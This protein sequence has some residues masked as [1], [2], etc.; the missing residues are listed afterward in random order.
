MNISPH[1][2]SPVLALASVL[3]L[4]A[5]AWWAYA[6]TRTPIGPGRRRLLLGL[7]LGASLLLSLMIGG[8]SLGLERR[9]ERPPLLRVL[10]DA[11]ASMA[12]PLAEGSSEP[13]RY[14]R[15]LDLLDEMR[16]R[17]GDRLQIEA[18]AFGDG[19]MGPELPYVPTA[20]VTDMGATLAALP[21]AGPGEALLLLSDGVDT[22]GNLWG[23]GLDR[24]RAL[25]ALVLGD[26]VPPPDLRIEDVET[27]SVLRV[28]SRLPMTVRLG[29][30]GDGPRSG[31]IRIL[32]EERL[33]AEQN[34]EIEPDED[35]LRI[36]FSLE[37]EGPGRHG[38]DIEVDGVGPDSS[39]ENNRRRQNLRVVESR[40]R[41]LVLAGRPDWELAALIQGLRGEESLQLEVVTAGPVGGTML[42]RDGAPWTP[43]ESTIHGLLLH[44]WHQTWDP[45]LL[46]DLPLR[47][48]VLFMPGWLERPGRSSL[49]AEWRLNPTPAATLGR[50]LLPTWGEDA[51][52]HAA[53]GGTLIAGIRPGE[54]G[55]LESVLDNPI[56]DGR[57]LMRAEGHPVLTARELGGQRLVACSGRGFWRWPLR[58][59]DGQRLHAELFSGLLRWLA[60]ED[61]PE[62]LVLEWAEEPV[63]MRSTPIR[64]DV[65]DA[66][67]NPLAAAELEW[68]LE[69]ADTL[70][71]SGPLMTAGETGF[72]GELPALPVGRYDLTLAARLDGGERL[73]RKIPIT[74]LAPRRELMELASRPE[75]LRWLAA[76]GGGLFLRDGDESALDGALAFTPLIENSRRV[77][78]LW[79]HPLAFLLLLT[80]LGAEWGLRK[81]FGMI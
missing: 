14:E 41:I 48:G 61:P 69:Q 23:A 6:R 34:W 26:S 59:D 76:R 46:A 5:W 53:L 63:A 62:R 27:L 54:Q 1:L 78:R 58:G 2:E 36:D 75:T 65:F 70:V 24:G 12:R 42:T 17:W 71:A 49:P 32:E 7:R 56:V 33:L 31:S 20:P 47:G 15:A 67:F 19:L 16:E 10:V 64:V 11:S 8:L 18:E 4:F 3:A 9:I 51:R 29:R 80:L 57:V 40:L 50:E 74:A 35:G 77:L 44:S 55:E 60:R 45:Q 25:H 37:I 72:T 21:P 68:T 28:G 52:R 81:R 43:G 38:L 22:E 39:P 30:R 13:S 79:Q 73:E 66:D